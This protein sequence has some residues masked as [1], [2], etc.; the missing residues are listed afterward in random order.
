MKFLS[1]FFFYGFLFILSVS[2]C[3]KDD[4]NDGVGGTPGSCVIAYT[5]D[6][7]NFSTEVIACLYNDNTL[8]VGSIG[9]DEAMIQI[10]PI[11][12]TGTYVQGA[13]PD[14]E[15]RIFINLDDGTQ[16]FGA[17]ATVNVTS[18]GNNGSS[19][20]FSGDFREISDLTM[21]GPVYPISNGTFNA[22]F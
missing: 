14:V 21:T 4:N 6:G 1:K 5:Y 13:D 22:D 11:S 8:N 3:K 12:A 16:L 2:S 19:G 10:D 20:T 9:V 15:V 7:S 17:G 18:L